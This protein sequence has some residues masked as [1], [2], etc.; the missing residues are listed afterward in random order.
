[1][2]FDS[3]GRFRPTVSSRF[4]CRCF[5]CR[6]VYTHSLTQPHTF[7]TPTHA[8]HNLSCSLFLCLSLSLYH[9]FSLFSLSP[10]LSLPPSVS[11]KQARTHSL[12]LHSLIHPHCTHNLSHLLA[13]SLSRCLLRAFSSS[14]AVYVCAISQTRKVGLGFV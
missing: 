11:L 12:I 7:L 4:C 8:S 6:S 14:Q 2:P 10:V 1:M 13:P 5:S 9:A 3:V